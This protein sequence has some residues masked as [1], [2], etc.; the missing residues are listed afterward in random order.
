MILIRQLI[1]GTTLALV[2]V[3]FILADVL[4][5][6]VILPWVR[7]RPGARDRVLTGWVQGLRWLIFAV[8]RGVGRARFE[9]RAQI[10][11][12]GGV[13]VVM[14]HQS[15][16]DIPVAF[17]CVPSGYPLMVTHARYAR[18]I[19]LVSHVI[20]LYGHIP[21]YPGRTGREE[22]ERLADAARAARL[23]IVIYP[24]GH[25]TRDG[26]IRVWKR[27]GLEAFL[28]AREWTVYVVVVDGLW[29][30][31]RLPDFIRNLTRVRCRAESA[32]PFAYDGRGRASHEEFVDRLHRVMCDK[33]SEMRRESGPSD[34]GAQQPAAKGE[35]AG[36]VRAT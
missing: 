32:G 17:A 34:K 10:P 35:A 12:Q 29:R 6:L 20:N 3:L 30:A 16:L 23:P 22:L 36:A 24:E 8:V 9:I 21:V 25:R 28:S 14:N 13:L 4:T 15:L 11:G 5:H 31:A 1:G 19:P 26:E 2:G 33:L 27:A 18:G 7:L